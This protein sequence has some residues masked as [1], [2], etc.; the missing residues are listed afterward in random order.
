MLRGLAK[1]RNRRLRDIGDAALEIEAAM[2]APDTSEAERH[3]PATTRWWAI[4][5]GGFILVGAVIGLTL[6]PGADP[7]PKPVT[8]LVVSIDSPTVAVFGGAFDLSPDGRTLV[9]VRERAGKTQLYRREMHSLDHQ[10]VPG[11]EGASEPFFSPDG[12]WV[13]FVADGLV[14]KVPISGGPPVTICDAPAQMTSA[15]WGQDDSIIMG[16]FELGLLQVSTSGGVPQTI[17]K[18]RFEKGEI[19]YTSATLL[20]GNRVVVFTTAYGSPFDTTIDLLALDTGERRTLM[21]G[22][23]A[24]YVAETRHLIVIKPDGTAVAVPFDV[25]WLEITG[26]P[27][28]VLEGIGTTTA[29]FPLIDVSQNGSLLYVAGKMYS[30]V[31][32]LQWLDRE[33]R[34]TPFGVDAQGYIAPTFSPDGRE[35]A[36]HI[37]AP[38]GRD[39]WVYDV[40]T[41]TPRRLT[42]DPAPDAMPLWSPDGQRIVFESLRDRSGPFLENFRWKRPRSPDHDEPETTDALWLDK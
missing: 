10:P 40:A 2:T 37:M 21:P 42:F 38:E 14:R 35:L 20:P 8:R 36:L 28:Q 6:L 5:V 26:E 33:G 13:G 24:F 41:A 3:A 23:E 19:G 11:T 34:V 39:V 7:E 17:A 12:E 32:Q 29:G 25:E 16:T 18:L 9:H 4:G 31:N 1:D 15:S 22:L 27:V 30:V